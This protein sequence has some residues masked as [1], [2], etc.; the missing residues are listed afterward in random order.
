M[1]NSELANQMSK[2]EFENKMDSISQI[3]RAINSAIT[4]K[5]IPTLQNSLGMQGNGFSTKVDLRSSGLNRN[6]EVE[7]SRKMRETCSKT[8]SGCNQ[9]NQNCPR[10]Q[11]LVN[12]QN[13]DLG[14]DNTICY[15][16][17]G[18][19]VRRWMC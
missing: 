8:C 11:S 4:E 10:K 2:K 1:I 14:C 3:L 12:S 16:R 15:A 18:S 9:F 19:A 6:P 7:N 13:T 5:I 17:H